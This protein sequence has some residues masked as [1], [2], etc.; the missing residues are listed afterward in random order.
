MYRRKKQYLIRW[1]GYGEDNDTWE[2]ESVLQSCQEALDAFQKE[3]GKLKD[4]SDNDG[5]DE[6]ST[7]ESTEVQTN[8]K[9]KSPEKKVQNKSKRISKAKNNIE[10]PEEKEDSGEE[11]KSKEIKIINNDNQEKK[12]MVKGRK[13]DIK[14]NETEEPVKKKK[15]EDV[16]SDESVTDGKN[17][18]VSALTP[19][20]Q[21]QM[22]EN[23]YVKFFVVSHFRYTKRPHPKVRYAS[24][25]K[26]WRVWE[27]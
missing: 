21:Q 23:L 7:R 24:V 22:F 14:D 19:L 3:E 25:K 5:D 10:T 17:Y 13:K 11:M 16:T 1:K 2:N 26:N 15:K 27:I 4:E 20:G 18:E 12:K 9:N 8:D 6:E